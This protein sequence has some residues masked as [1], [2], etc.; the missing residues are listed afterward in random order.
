MQVT[1][2]YVQLS[3]VEMY[4]EICGEGEPLL[5]IHGIDSDSRLW[6]LHFEAFGHEYRTIRFDL[7]GFG[8]TAMPAGEFQLL[9]DMH[10]LLTQ[11]GVDSAHI[12]GYS[13]GGTVA[14]SFALKYP[15]MVRSLSLI[16]AGMVGHKWSEEVMDYHRKFQKTIKNQ[17]QDEMMKLLYWKSVYGPYREE[18]GLEEVCQKLKTMFL[19]ALSK[20]REGVPLPTGNAIEELD[21]IKVPTYV[22]VGELDFEDY[23]KIADVYHEGVPNTKKEVFPNAAHL[24]PLENPTLFVEK[25]LGFLQTTKVAQP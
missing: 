22:L 13:Y 7:R 1:K 2:G 25:M 24:L 20:P 21:N 15:H 12:V 19:H 5:L 3:N 4:Y 10:D 23:H 17:D 11:L 8:N 16:G 9:D 18:K 6:D 14:P